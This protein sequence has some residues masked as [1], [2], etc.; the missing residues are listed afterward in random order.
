MSRAEQLR[1]VSVKYF[2]ASKEAHAEHD[3]LRVKRGELVEEQERI[4]AQIESLDRQ[5]T[6]LW[7]VAHLYGTLAMA[8]ET[9]DEELMADSLTD[10]SR[11]ESTGDDSLDY[12]HV[13]RVVDLDLGF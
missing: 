7:E 9:A 1:D 12:I 6:T 8:T 4:A 3:A 2:E 10:F 5:A 13:E 11:R